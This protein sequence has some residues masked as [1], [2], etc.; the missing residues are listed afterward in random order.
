MAAEGNPSAWKDTLKEAVADAMK[1]VPIGE[2]L[3]IDKIEVRNKSNPV[4][5]Y[6]I[7]LAPTP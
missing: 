3:V 7:W 4:H 5:E 1:N 6:R 2:S